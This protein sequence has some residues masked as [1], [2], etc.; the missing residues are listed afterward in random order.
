MQ[1]LEKSIALDIP[2]TNQ[3]VAEALV[4]HSINE[5]ESQPKLSK[6]KSMMKSGNNQSLAHM[7][8]LSQFNP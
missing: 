5:G 1:E 4:A 2:L 7:H 8:N 6:L 3:P